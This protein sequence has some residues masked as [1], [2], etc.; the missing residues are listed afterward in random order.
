M[1]RQRVDQRK[2]SLFCLLADG[3]R[4]VLRGGRGVDGLSVVPHIVTQLVCAAP[5]LTV[6]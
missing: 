1:G 3:S 5:L 6:G 4:Q 2:A